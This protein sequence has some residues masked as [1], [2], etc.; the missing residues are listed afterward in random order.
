[1]FLA[2][3][4]PPIIEGI[5]IFMD[6]AI[7]ELQ[8]KNNSTEEITAIS[9]YNYLGQIM[10]TWNANLNRRIISLPINLATGVY[11]AKISTKNK[12]IVGKIL[13]H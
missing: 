7:R 8:I 1:V 5:H 3:E 2:A 4:S 10:K 6:N 12:I 11:V 13:I 9:L